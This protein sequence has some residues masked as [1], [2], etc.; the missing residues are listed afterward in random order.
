VQRKFRRR[1][2]YKPYLLAIR[3]YG[4]SQ[5]FHEDFESACTCSEAM[6]LAGQFPQDSGLH[7]AQ[8]LRDDL[9]LLKA[10]ELVDVEGASASVCRQLE[11]NARQQ[12]CECL[13]DL[14]LGLEMIANSFQLSLIPLACSLPIYEVASQ[15]LSSLLPAVRSWGALQ[16][17]LQSGSLPGQLT[18]IIYGVSSAILSRLTDESWFQEV[19]KQ[20]FDRCL[21]VG[22]SLVASI[23]ACV[24][25]VVQPSHVNAA[26]VIEKMMPCLQQWGA[27]LLGCSAQAVVLCDQCGCGKT[28]KTSQMGTFKLIATIW[29]DLLRLLT[30]LPVPLRQAAEQVYSSAFIAAWRLFEVSLF[31]GTSALVQTILRAWYTRHCARMSAGLDIGQLARSMTSLPHRCVVTQDNV[32][33]LL[34]GY[35]SAVYAA[36]T[37][38]DG[39]EQALKLSR[40]WLQTA[41][42][43]VTTCGESL[44]PLAAR[45]CT[46]VHA[47]HVCAGHALGPIGPVD[48]VNDLEN[49]APSAADACAGAEAAGSG[50]NA[51]APDPDP[52]SCIRQLILPRCRTC[53]A[54]A[55][56]GMTQ[57]ERQDTI[58]ALCA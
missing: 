43:V 53:A 35:R 10:G 52:E 4:T 18:A 6:L 22:T 49:R 21:R 20:M 54:A 44:A 19:G 41:L 40:F 5:P 1:W 36:S 13:A 9:S 8:S 12:P 29:K 55:L 38:K 3:A 32:V 30:D 17:S 37:V 27:V 58:N 23:S 39:T 33:Q 48:A 15:Y 34:Q 56:E 24:V 57:E 50:A 42:K 46:L 51:E 28:A 26:L 14:C 45:M 25:A 2:E 11:L 47:L 7:M 16:D 31:N